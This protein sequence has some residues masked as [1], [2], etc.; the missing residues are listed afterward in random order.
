MNDPIKYGD[1]RKTIPEWLLYLPPGYNSRALN[2]YQQLGAAKDTG[3]S[4]IKYDCIEDAID[5]AFRWCD[6]VEG[7]LFWNKVYTH[8]CYEGQEDKYILPPLPDE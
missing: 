8:Y 4:P 6:T 1:S 7:E 3:H 2:N 5:C